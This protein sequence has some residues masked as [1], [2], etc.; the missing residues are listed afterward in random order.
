MDK[1]QQLETLYQVRS[2]IL[3]YLDQA[4]TDASRKEWS[5][6]LDAK[7]KEIDAFKL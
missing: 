7:Q 5:D 4:T 2:M 6:K 1:Y 3:F